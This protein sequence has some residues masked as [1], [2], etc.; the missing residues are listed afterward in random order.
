MEWFPWAGKRA[1]MEATINFFNE[2]RRDHLIFG[3]IHQR[4]DES[5]KRHYAARNI[6]RRV[7]VLHGLYADAPAVLYQTRRWG[8]W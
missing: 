6:L 1:V 7:G 5:F 4:H 2:M 3:Y 8:D